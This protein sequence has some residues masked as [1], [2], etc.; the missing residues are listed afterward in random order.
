MIA[1]AI[2]ELVAVG[3]IEVTRKGVA[4]PAEHRN[5]ALY[6]L[7]YAPEAKGTSTEGKHTYERIESREE[8]E[9]SVRLAS[10]AVGTRDI[11]N[12]HKSAKAKKTEFRPQM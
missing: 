3:L 11:A 8:A 5:A 4:G 10:D 1:R 6:S 9:A 2:R 7:T 12:G